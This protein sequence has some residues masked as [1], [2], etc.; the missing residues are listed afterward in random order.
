[1]PDIIFHFHNNSRQ[2]AE[3]LLLATLPIL[4]FL[5]KKHLKTRINFLPTGINTA[6]MHPYERNKTR[7]IMHKC[8]TID[9][10]I[11]YRKLKGKATY[12]YKNS[13][14]HHWRSYCSTWTALHRSQQQHK[15]AIKSNTS[16]IYPAK[17]ITDF[18]WTTHS[19]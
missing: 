12:V 16:E 1:M 13:A 9:N 2:N 7:N 3:H 17:S 8:K 10:S 19:T 15:H 11:N 4:A 5:P 6:N 18:H 14:K